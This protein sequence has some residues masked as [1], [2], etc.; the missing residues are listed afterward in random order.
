VG[1]PHSART[2]GTN[3]R[4]EA[5]PTTDSLKTALRSSLEAAV[6][7]G[8][9]RAAIGMDA[10]THLARQLASAEFRRLRAD[11][12]LRET[13]EFI[14]PAL[15]VCEGLKGPSFGSSLAFLKKNLSGSSSPSWTREQVALRAAQF[16]RDPVDVQTMTQAEILR[17]LPLTDRDLLFDR[18]VGRAAFM[19]GRDTRGAFLARIRHANQTLHAQALDLDALLAKYPA[20]GELAEASRKSLES[21][22]SSHR[23]RLPSPGELQEHRVDGEAGEVALFAYWLQCRGSSELPSVLKLGPEER[24]RF[25]EDFALDTHRFPHEVEG[26]LDELA[27]APIASGSIGSQGSSMSG[28]IARASTQAQRR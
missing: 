19:P 18:L 11:E 17:V 3:H 14:V 24:W 9:L 22:A 12:Q 21:F 20:N 5:G 26:L 16:V 25:V 27:V 1:G 2:V 4:I 13:L 23:G 6:V 7:H 15:I 8:K 28:D 10:P